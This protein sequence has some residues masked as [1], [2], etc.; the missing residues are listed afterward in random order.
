MREVVEA[1]DLAGITTAVHRA[2]SV[3]GEIAKTLEDEARAAAT[4]AVAQ[5]KAESAALQAAADA[6]QGKLLTVFSTKGGVGKSLVATNTAV[7]LSDAGKKVC[8]IDL[9]VNS[10]DVAIML[11][12]SPSRT[13]NDLVAFNG[14]IDEEAITSI[15][16][17][18]SDRLSIV[19]A[20]V[21]LDSPDH[22][23]SVDIGNMIDTL[24]SMFDYI[25]V[26]TSGVFDDNALTALDRTNTI[27]L[28]ATLDIPALKG[29]KLATGTLDL[30]NFSRDTWKFVLNRA[31]GKVG[32]TVDE[33][34]STLGLKADTTLVSSREVLT[35]VNRGEALVRAYPSHPNSKAI[36]SFAQ[37]FI[38]ATD[39]GS[40]GRKASGSRLRLRKD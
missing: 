31:D 13:I 39:T 19:A 29:L 36:V 15:L 18:H 24:K 37:S 20:P 30:L 23:T 7:A 12:L 33:F 4:S 34:E 40:R 22:A 21:R 8:L 1:S 35:A 11:Q 26:D 38:G 14:M 10:G 32:L 28:V 27:I 5:V 6:P 16:T 17:R 25:V 3:A 2:R 9:D